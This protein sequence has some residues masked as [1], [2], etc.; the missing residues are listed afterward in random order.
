M[1]SYRHITDYCMQETL[2]VHGLSAEEISAIM[3]DLKTGFN[4]IKSRK[5][6]GANPILDITKQDEDLEELETLAEAIR[7]RFNHVLVVGSGGSGL[8]G[9]ALI[10][11]S[12]CVS[13]TFDFLD[14]IDPHML[15]DIMAKIQI[16]NTCFIVI[17]KSGKTIETLS[18]TYALIGRIKKKIGRTALPAQFIMITEPEE[19]EGQNPMRQLA[20]EYNMRVLDHKKD[21]GGRFSILTNVGLLPAIIAGID[22][23]ALRRGAASVVRQLE[24]AETPASFAPALGA[25][26]QYAF[27]QRS[28]NISVLFPYGQR[29][30]GLSAWYRQCW[31]ESLG[32]KGKGTTPV[33]A[34]GTTDQHSQLQLYLSGPKDKIFNM[35]TIKREGSGDDIEVLNSEHPDAFYMIDKTLGDVMAA[36]QK[37]TIETLI[38]NRCPT[39][40][41]EIEKLDEEHFGALI[42]HFMLEIMFI[43]FLFE[44]NPF[45]QPAVEESK[46]LTRKYLLAEPCL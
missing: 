10:A 28:Y 43:S 33:C 6:S 38:H 3:D 39:R 18:Q 26:I 42:M 19:A 5:F 14:N 35:L 30:S 36:Q 13:P 21:I 7:R 22:V 4:K 29:L 9:S 32:K 27:Y 11:M 15:D 12:P 20:R 25:A 37:A 46:K 34:M 8:S 23:R 40:V 31:A 16:E 17:S 45:D 44:I 24:E 2:G 41:I 1:M